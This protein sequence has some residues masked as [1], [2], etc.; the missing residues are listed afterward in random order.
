MVGPRLMRSPSVKLGVNAA[1]QRLK[2]KP[3][4][5]IWFNHTIPAL[6]PLTSL[7]ADLMFDSDAVV[8]G[9]STGEQGVNTAWV[10]G[11]IPTE[12]YPC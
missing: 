1:A 5:Y 3:T 9:S 6:F 8:L 11:S 12:S 2:S 10:G 4:H 7:V